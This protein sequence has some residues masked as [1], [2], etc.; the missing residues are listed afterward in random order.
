MLRILRNRNFE[1]CFTGA[2]VRGVVC[3]LITLCL[4]TSV[5]FVSEAVAADKKKADS[6]EE[7][8]KSVEKQKKNKQP[9]EKPYTVKDK[10][11]LHRELKD[12]ME[13]FAANY[14]EKDKRLKAMEDKNVNLYVKNIIVN[15]RRYGSA[16]EADRKGHTE[17]ATV[18]KSSVDTQEKIGSLLK[19]LANPKAKKRQQMLEKLKSLVSRRFDMILKVKQLQY[20]TLQK[21]LERLENL[22]EVRQIEL[23]KLKDTKDEA[24]KQRL[25]DLLGNDEK[26]KWD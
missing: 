24:I 16:F 19:T 2:G 7:D 17:L 20:D 23:E 21:R 9:A 4:V 26:I 3:L 13:W 10:E 1:R 6:K 12:F 25:K 18:M 11:R 5:A 8:A 14:P 22:V 15:R